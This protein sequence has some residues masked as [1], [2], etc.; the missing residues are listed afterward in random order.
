[1]PKIIELPNNRV[2]LVFEINE[3]DKTGVK[4]IH[5]VGNHAFR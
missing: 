5:F 4:D 2:N 3:G 1:M